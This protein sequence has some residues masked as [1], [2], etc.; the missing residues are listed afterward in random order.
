MKQRSELGLLAARIAI[1]CF[2][3]LWA[4]LAGAQDAAEKAAEQIDKSLVHIVVTAIPAL[5][6]QEKPR[7]EV[8]RG[9]GFVVSEDGFILTSFHLIKNIKP[10]GIKDQS[11]EIQA[12]IGPADN[13]GSRR[14]LQLVKSDIA[15]DLLLLKG[16]TMDSPYNPVK[17][18]SAADIAKLTPTDELVTKGFQRPE[19][20]TE[21]AT[22]DTRSDGKI[23]NKNS[24]SPHLWKVA[25]TLNAGQS[26]SPIFLEDGRVVGIAA[27]DS[28]INK[29]TYFMIPAYFADS[30]LSHVRMGEMQKQIAELIAKLNKLE[31]DKIEPAVEDLE[32][33]ARNFEW[34]AAV[35]DGE[36]EIAYE[37]LTQRG[38]KIGFVRVSATPIIFKKD[39]LPE[40]VSSAFV[41]LD[42][43]SESDDLKP[44]DFDKEARRAAIAT[45]T[46]LTKV[47]N[48][49]CS[50]GAAYSSDR[51]RLV[52][53][54][55]LEDG[56]ALASR[57]LFVEAIFRKKSECSSAPQG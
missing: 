44:R 32:Q 46:L 55:F 35:A 9:T 33:V 16:Q 5:G 27:A 15:F 7:E 47:K 3:F 8:A 51:M 17:F 4:G 14:Q 48:Q 20:P 28:A 40:L 19:N 45:P 23:V 21:E 57:T 2:C 39:G 42:G 56:K 11:M 36:I 34:T 49:F 10:E 31:K 50:A 18:A 12:S 24:S 29:H 38:P 52:I 22:L 41:D 1:A 30:L 53:E 43:N 26:G 25:L 37:T 13:P 54:P 6:G